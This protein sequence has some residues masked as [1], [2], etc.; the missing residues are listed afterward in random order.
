MV[1]NNT[2]ILTKVQ[3]A[4]KKHIVSVSRR[5]FAK[6]GVDNTT[7]NDIAEEAK[8]GRR[9]IYLYFK[10]KNEIFDAIVNQ[11]LD[12]VY[13]ELTLIK[14]KQMGTDEKLFDFMY[15]HLDCMKRIVT[16]NGSL[17][18]SFFND[19]SLVEKARAKFDRKEISLIEEILREGV[20][21]GYFNIYDTPTMAMLLLNAVKGLEVP[22][23]Y[24]WVK[25]KN[26][27]KSELIKKSVKQL[28]FNGIK[29]NKI[30][31]YEIVGR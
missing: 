23:I 18:A 22:F 27:E 8:K 26:S 14:D 6:K 25:N 19:I 5:L 9:T 1:L 2:K 20:N 11:E 13:K 12:R 30:Q 29:N 21:K 31:T 3:I 4:T 28:M 24:S 7:M 10:N 15:A 17:R 16:R